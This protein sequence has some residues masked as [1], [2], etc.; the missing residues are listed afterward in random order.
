VMDCFNKFV[1]TSHL[2]ASVKKTEMMFVS[3]VMKHGAWFK[4]STGFNLWQSSNLHWPK[5]S[6][7]II[8]FFFFFFLLINKSEC[9]SVCMFKINSLTP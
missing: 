1:H 9:V 4:Y 2:L 7:Q 8:F 6:A 5:M 3:Y